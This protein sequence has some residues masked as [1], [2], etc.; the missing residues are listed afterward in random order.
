MSDQ[1]NIILDATLLTSLMTCGRFADLR[2]NHRLVSNRG[3]SN[4][5]EIGSIIHKFMETYYGSIVNKLSKDKAVGFA[6]AAAEMYVRGCSQCT[7]FVQSHTWTQEEREISGN[8]VCTDNCILRPPCGHDVN[9]YPGVA[10]TPRD[11]DAK[12]TGWQWALD[13]CDQYLQFYKNDFWIPLEVENVRARIL[14]EDE[15]VR[16]MWKAKLDLVM[17]TNTSIVP[18]DHKTMKQNRDTLSLNNQFMGQCLV[19]DSRN[20][21][22]NKIG[23]QTT[24][25]PEEK[26]K[27]AMV[28]YSAERLLEWQSEILPY[29]AKMLMAYDEMGYF[30]PNFSNCEGKYGYCIFKKVCEADPDERERVL[31]TD[32]LV[33]PE[34]NPSNPSQG[35][36]VPGDD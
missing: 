19:T 15:D 8:H 16:I 2:F 14:Y 33:G 21:I 13:T 5:L 36:P 30:P 17:D 35:A 32:F 26:F 4:S 29:Y 20:M 11:S 28:S 12:H 23:L 1:K 9:E 7:D 34:W 31:K 24:L 27:R 25:K 18:V 10:N 3:K 22:V 6:F